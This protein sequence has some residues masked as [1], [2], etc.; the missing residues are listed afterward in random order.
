[1]EVCRDLQILCYENQSFAVLSV[2]GISDYEYA[3]M[4]VTNWLKENRIEPDGEPF[5]VYDTTKSYSNPF[6]KLYCP[7]KN[8][9]IR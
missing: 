3:C 5:A 4:L 9:R 6:M 7:V 8:V 2:N 1:M